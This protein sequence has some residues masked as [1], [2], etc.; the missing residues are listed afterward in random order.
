MLKR[1]I[2]ILFFTN[3]LLFC[4]VFTIKAQLNADFTANNVSGCN[5]LVVS[6]QNLSTGAP[7]DYFW[8]FGNG[9]TSTNQNPGAI[10]TSP[11]TYTVSLRITKG[12]LFDIE[13]KT[14]YI[15]VFENPKIDIS[16]DPLG[17][18]APLNV[19]FTDL[20]T[21]SAPIVQ[22]TWA[23]GDG[24]TSSLNAPMHTYQNP[25]NYSVTIIIKDAN[26]CQSDTVYPSF[27]KASRPV[28]ADFSDGP[29]EACPPSLPITT[30]NNSIG[31]EGA[32]TY[33][34]DFGDGNSSSAESPSH[35]YS[36]NGVQYLYDVKLKAEDVNGCADSTTQ[37][38]YAEFLDFNTDFTISDQLP[39]L[40]TASIFTDLTSPAADW[41]KWDFGD[42][43]TSSNQNPTHTYVDTGVYSV[44]LIS[45]RAS[46]CYDTLFI[47]NY[48]TVLPLPESGFTADTQ[49]SCKVPFTVNF[50]DTSKYAVGWNW[51]F[52]DGNTSS[53][54]NPTHV[55]VTPG[56]FRVR[57]IVTGLNGCTDRDGK[58]NYIQI[59]EPVADF[60][61]LPLE[62]CAPHTVNFSD[63]ST[64]VEP[65]L[66]Y[67]WDFGDG[68]TGV[69]ANPAH[70]YLSAGNYTVTLTI[71]N[72]AGCAESEIKTFYVQIGEIPTTQFTATPLIACVEQDIDF[73]ELAN[74]EL[75]YLWIFGDGSFSIDPNP[76]KTY[77]DTGV[78]DVTLI[79]G[80]NGCY[81]SL[82]KE[83]YITIL[84]PV[85]DFGIVQN[86]DSILHIEFYDNSRGADI[87]TWKFGDGTTS[88]EQN[89]SHKYATPG[90]YSIRL[91]VTN[92][93]TGCVDSVIRN[94]N[95]TDI[96]GGFTEDPPLGCSPLNVT[97]IDTSLDAVSWSWDF[98][99]GGTSTNQN[100]TY[101]YQN[102]GLYTVQLAIIDDNGCPDTV[103][104]TDAINLFGPLA[105]FI[106]DT[107]NGCAPLTVSFTDTSTSS[108]PL[109][110]YFW[111]FG[112]GNTSAEKNPTH[113]YQDAEKYT[114]S[115]KV[116]DIS[117]CESSV[118]FS[119]LISATN[120]FVDFSIDDNLICQATAIQFTNLS[121]AT[122]VSYLWDFGDGD[123]SHLQNPS[124]TF[125]F[126]TSTF[127]DISLTVADTNGCFSN[128]TYASMIE[129]RTPIAL[130]DN[131]PKQGACPP[132][133]VSF[134]DNSLNDIVSW[135]WDFGDSTTSSQQTPQKV[136][137]EPG[138]YDVKL[139]VGTVEGCT[140]TLTNYGVAEVLGPSGTYNYNPDTGCIGQEVMFTAQTTNTQNF[141]W[142]FGDGNLSAGLEDSILRTYD[143]S[144]I[145][146]PILI[147]DDGK[148]CQFTLGPLDSIIIDTVPVADFGMDNTFHCY[149]GDVEF[150]DSTFSTVP[151]VSYLWDFGDGS[152]SRQQQPEYEYTDI[153]IYSV[154]LKV[155]NIFGCEDNIV[156]LSSIVI[157][158]GPKA[159]FSPS[160]IEGCIPLNIDFTN[161]SKKNDT[162]SIMN[163][164]W[165]F[166]NGS[167]DDQINASNLYST[168]GV[169]TAQLFIIDSNGCEDVITKTIEAYSLPQA[170]FSVGDTSHCQEL[171]VSIQNTS[172]DG[173]YLLWNFG[174]GSQSVDYSPTHSYKQS[175]SYTI[176]LT[177]ATVNGCLDSTANDICVFVAPTLFFPNAFTPN[178]DGIND[179]FYSRDYAID[180]YLLQIFD[181]WG[182]VV[183]ETTRIEDKWDGTFNG[184]DALIG[185]YVYVATGI[186]IT[187][188]TYEFK[189]T[190][191]LIR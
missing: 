49:R 135:Q 168:A 12:V 51:N 57:L 100:P 112:D 125:D 4:H 108:G 187:G 60:S 186:G 50:S 43:N 74:N 132:L 69:G 42:G 150:T 175:G 59:I 155:T 183:F 16:A 167:F 46:S 148:G 89:P 73:T 130:F 67:S 37:S 15:T 90:N 55:Y 53:L 160:T 190:L 45:K 27:V 72:A 141:T 24:N 9:N 122:V 19:N 63:L 172:I 117:S 82:T 163:Y 58:S 84:V 146:Y 18:C 23:F 105:G 70:T 87:R 147:L 77:G 97:F 93:T 118:T 144:G 61:A 76:T 21:S 7:D 32:L 157:S 154:N 129:F 145:F 98:G 140:D 123:T 113:I 38:A 79:V 64:S 31:G 91:T 65:I 68:F 134:T 179:E 101:Q 71:N 39:C 104:K 173:D 11:G 99:D 185:V 2:T 30:T 66:S 35:S 78:Y 153:G 110:I 136:Y 25:G 171:T 26:G 81:D 127:F 103:V 116:T 107:N 85:A 102:N 137:T 1:L 115:L 41:W 133:L 44:S 188:K 162:V 181:R 114:V 177:T 156:K 143:R 14:A 124:H 17:G 47:P 159:N 174:D 75:E 121:A 176:S 83:N 139:V 22:W 48:V 119:N 34:W 40:N 109:I 152:T 169:Y 142:D 184:E 3:T 158:D 138:L 182:E 5:P 88:V 128:Q 151:I 6:F 106:L 164:Q 80:N 95:I 120:P 29:F 126:D 131:D 56:S 36:F 165:D 52:G 33:S 94:I 180:S 191:S 54:Q 166:G 178:G 13:L 10:Y 96:K 170:A 92:L 20:S 28:I 86:C 62:G 8:E 149:K 111:D 189:G 161:Y